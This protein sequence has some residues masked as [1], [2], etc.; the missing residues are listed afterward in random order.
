MDKEN[1]A[2]GEIAVASPLNCLFVFARWQHKTHSLATICNCMFWLI[3]RLPNLSCPWGSGP[4]PH[5][6]FVSPDHNYLYLPNDIKNLSNVL[7]RRHKNATNRRTTEHTMEKCVAIGKTDKYLLHLPARKQIRPILQLSGP[8]YNVKHA[9]GSRVFGGSFL[10]SKCA[11]NKARAFVLYGKQ[12]GG[13]RTFWAKP[14][15][16]RSSCKQRQA[17]TII[18]KAVH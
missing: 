5:L 11:C 12:N 17:H 8:V 14:G 4:G 3:I 1:L 10:R 13:S 6:T 16:S 18:T 2:K 7:S 15:K 9:P